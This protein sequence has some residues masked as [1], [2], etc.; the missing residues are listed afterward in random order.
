MAKKQQSKK[1]RARRA[2]GTGYA[3]KTNSGTWKAH[4]PRRGGGHTV[5]GGFDTRESAEAWLDSLVTQRDEQRVDVASGRQTVS[6]R[7]DA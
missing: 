4:L 6:E 3:I 7:L 2:P 5:R 1:R